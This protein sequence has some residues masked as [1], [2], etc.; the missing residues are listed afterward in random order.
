MC[1]CF[2]SVRVASQPVLPSRRDI[3]RDQPL[4]STA[5]AAGSRQPAAGSDARLPWPTRRCSVRS[6]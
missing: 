3:D 5:K 2:S 6:F 1:R 4:M